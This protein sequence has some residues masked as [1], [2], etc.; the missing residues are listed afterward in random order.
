[1]NSKTKILNFSKEIPFNKL[2]KKNDSIVVGVSG[3]VDSMVLL[4]LLHEND[5]KKV[6]V[7]HLN[8]LIRKEST[9]DAKLVKEVCAKYKYSCVA[10]KINIPHLAKKDKLGIE[11]TGRRERYAFFEETRKKRK[12]KY[13]L[14]AHHADDQAETILL[15]L[16]RGTG[17]QGLM[18]IRK[19]NERI[20]RP[21]LNVT[22]E[23]I[24]KF[25]KK[26]KLRYR[27]DKSNKN[28]EYSRNFM[29]LKIIPQI[30][31]INPRFVSTIQSTQEIAENTQNLINQ[32]SE[33]FLK[34]SKHK[35]YSRERF[36]KLHQAIKGDIIR[37]I[38]ASKNSNT[39]NLQNSH[40]R[41][42][43][44]VIDQKE[45]GKKKEF[46]EDYYICTE[47]HYFF[48]SKKSGRTF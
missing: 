38:Y 9:Q 39:T 7:C 34:E 22:K 41:Q 36:R 1:M 11:E 46:G 29:R 30:K 47:K 35:K 24:E 27:L 3:G 17:I 6:T 44:K 37:K 5:C 4:H 31:K 18:G 45:S 14:T 23:E 28:T 20:L 2:F 25:A 32:L 19:K 15:N 26:M 13:I 33:A 16:I 48:I 42:I 43:L 21:M 12:A 8:H 10:R 40:I